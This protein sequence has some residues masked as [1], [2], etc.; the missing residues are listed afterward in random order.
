MIENETAREKSEGSKCEKTPTEVSKNIGANLVVD[1]AH[2]AVIPGGGRCNGTFGG[3][4]WS[5]KR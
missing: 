5:R 1:P 4:G 3:D 2:N